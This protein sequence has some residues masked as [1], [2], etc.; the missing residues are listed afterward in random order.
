VKTGSRS[1]ARRYARALLEVSLAKA[2]DGAP[3]AVR[4]DLDAL[5][6]LLRGN[7]ELAAVLQNP[8]VRAEVKKK[9]TAALAAR[10]KPTP[11]V[12][13]LLGM[14]AERDRLSLLPTIA[15]VFADAWNAHRGVIAADAV[16]AVELQP[17]QANALSA[18]LGAAAGLEVELRASVD[19][20]V[21]GGL[22]VRMG[23]KTYD[24]SVRAR[25]A[26]LRETL[27]GRAG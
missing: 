1:L 7:K 15:E 13:R 2:T 5:R 22:L 20:K 12:E 25:L 6:D 18:A 26:A 27:L 24:G 19:P 3:G 16:S 23:G 17:A 11:I 8:A 21:L 10:M 9:I 4:R 14:L